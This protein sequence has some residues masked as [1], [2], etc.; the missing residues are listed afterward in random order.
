MAQ[1]GSLYQDHGS[2]FVRYWETVENE[3]GTPSRKNPAHRLA[4]V[5]DFPKKSDVIPLKNQFMDRL[6]R[7]GF[8]PGSG[9][10]LVDFVVNTFLPA[11]ERRLTG[12]GLKCYRDTW[13]CHLKSRAGGLR[14]RDVRPMHIQNI[15]NSIEDEHGTKLAHGTYKTMKVTLSAIFTEAR[16]LGVY[17]G[18]N[19]TT[20]VRIPKGKKHGRKRLAYSLDEILRHLGLFTSDPIIVPQPLPRKRKTTRIT[21]RRTGIKA[22]V[23]VAGISASQMRA[24]IGVTAFAALR[25]GEI[26]GLWWDDDRGEVLAICRSVWNSTLKSTKTEEDVDEPGLVPVIRPLRLLLDAIRP[27]MAAGFMFPN[28][29]GGALDLDNIADRILKPVFEA[30][31]MQWKGWQAYRR[32]LATNLKELGVEDTTIQCILRHE[33]VSTTQ[34]FYIK[35]VPRVAQEAMRVLEEKIAC[36]AVVQQTAVN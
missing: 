17:D 5:K 13:N 26:R 21:R 8:D 28:R 4:S 24:I 12:A 36:T 27:E 20:G 35:T 9:V 30:N 33:D 32:G 7:I 29:C 15:L 19:P 10:T 25:K 2:W 22:E 34:R 31:G 18:A 6:N 1:Q 16:N 23:Y 11:C 14:L 3:D